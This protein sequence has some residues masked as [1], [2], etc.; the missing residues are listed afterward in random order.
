MT[1]DP[2][3]RDFT[4]NR[5][6]QPRAQVAMHGAADLLLTLWILGDC[7]A[8]SDPEI[9][10]ENYDLGA[11][12]FAAVNDDLSPELRDDIARIGVGEI[13]VGLLTLVTELPDNSSIAEFVDLLAGYDPVELRLR[14]LTLHG[15][16]PEEDLDV[17]REAAGGDADALSAVLSLP[18]FDDHKRWRDGLQYLLEQEPSQSHEAVTSIVRRFADE[19]FSPHAVGFRPILERDTDAKR[20]MAARMSPRRL[21][22]VATNGIDPSHYQRPILLV[23]HV[24]ARPWVVFTTASDELILCYPVADEYMDADPDAPP[25]W[26]IKTY[27]A[28]GDERRLR[29][30]RR[31]SRGPASLHELTAE[32]DA[33]KST[34][35]HHL[36]LLRAAGLI[37][38]TIGKDKEYSLRKNVV[39]ETTAF[40]QAYIGGNETES[41]EPEVSVPQ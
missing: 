33:S 28:L 29:I 12:W 17:A 36:M 6:P 37:R 27:K 9:A 2:Q 34:L 20:T 11:D 19:V 13:W 25:Q 8:D 7:F 14:L 26:L 4:G 40:L 16:V 1:T 15:V 35:H 23:P 3:V 10:W 38:V 30:L 32:L 21:V 24:V 31:L 22:E 5:R 18:A 39:P 41:G